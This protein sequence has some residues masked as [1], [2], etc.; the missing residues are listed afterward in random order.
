LGRAPDDEA[1][2]DGELCEGVDAEQRGADVNVVVAEAFTEKGTGLGVAGQGLYG[3]GAN[4]N[5]VVAEASYGPKHSD[6]ALFLRSLAPGGRPSQVTPPLVGKSGHGKVHPAPLVGVSDRRVG[7]RPE[8]STASTSEPSEL[9]FA[10]ASAASARQR[11]FVFF[12]FR[13]PMV[14]PSSAVGFALSLDDRAGECA[15]CPGP[16]STR[17]LCR[18]AWR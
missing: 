12:L 3:G 9:Y 4:V 17:G 18:P 6:L 7:A 11:T 5:V 8:R 1:A 16:R 15:C 13:V 14:G 2:A 10:T